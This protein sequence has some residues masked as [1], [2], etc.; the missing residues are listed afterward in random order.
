MAGS[1]VLYSNKDYGCE[2]DY[3]WRNKRFLAQDNT[4]FGGQHRHVRADRLT[5]ACPECS[6]DRHHR[7]RH[8]EL[9]AQ[10]AKLATRARSAR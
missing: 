10:L 4:K 6:D 5:H 7:N 9:A 1:G 8:R 2:W 3:D